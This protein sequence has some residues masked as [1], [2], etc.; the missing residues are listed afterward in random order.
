MINGTLFVQMI[1]FCVG[2]YLLK[3]L[4]LKPGFLFLKKEEQKEKDFNRLLVSLRKKIS[5]QEERQ[6]AQIEAFS[7]KVSQRIPKV[8]GYAIAKQDNGGK[9]HP[10]YDAS[11]YDK[12]RVIKDCAGN[13]VSSLIDGGEDV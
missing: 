11:K 7:Y 9:E 3:Y 4:I 5:E 2:Y 13:I 12:E 6:A 1:H 8:S 10:K